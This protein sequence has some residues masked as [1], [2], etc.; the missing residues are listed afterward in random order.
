MEL[1]TANPQTGQTG[2]TNMYI[3]AVGL[4]NF[5][6][7]KRNAMKRWNRYG[8]YYHSNLQCFRDI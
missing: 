8:G 4:L 1:N 7:H 2:Q 3:V 6:D 5:V